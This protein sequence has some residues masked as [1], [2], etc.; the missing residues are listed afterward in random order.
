[1]RT[2]TLV[3]RTVHDNIAIIFF[4]LLLA[5]FGVA[6]LIIEAIRSHQS[7]D[8]IFKL[9][10]RI[11]ELERERVTVR[12]AS[13]E[14]LVPVVMPDRWVPA[15]GAATTSDGG[16]LILVDRI[17]PAEQTAQLTVRVDG[18]A[19]KRSEPLRAGECFELPGK[20]GI[21]LITLFGTDQV[22]ARIGVGLRSKHSP[23]NA[24]RSL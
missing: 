24:A 10:H 17:G 1:M 9:R 4:G 11:T 14:P 20:S 3:L 16:C 19:V 8:E 18:Y 7:R 6:W 5:V 15:G 23:A 21:Y 13:P 12:T 2:W 22:Q